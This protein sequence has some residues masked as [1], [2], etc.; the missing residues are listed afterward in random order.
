[1]VLDVD[2]RF[3]DDCPELAVVGTADFCADFYLLLG[4]Y[5]LESGDFD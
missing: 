3:A 5:F 4:L 1:M 2:T